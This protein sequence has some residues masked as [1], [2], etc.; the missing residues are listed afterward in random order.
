MAYYKWKSGTY[1]TTRANFK[2]A[3]IT[4]AMSSR[5]NLKLKK[6]DIKKR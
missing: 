1:F 3:I 6:N 4:Y 5:I 2:E